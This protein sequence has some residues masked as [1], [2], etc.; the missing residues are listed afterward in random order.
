MGTIKFLHNDDDNND[1]DEDND[2]EI[3]IAGL[4]LRNRQANIWGTDGWRLL[5]YPLQFFHQG[6]TKQN[7]SVLTSVQ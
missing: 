1:Y 5:P 4:F 6:I 7:L 2:L 3:T